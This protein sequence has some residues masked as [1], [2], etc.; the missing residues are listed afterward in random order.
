M[1]NQKEPEKDLEKEI[2]EGE[3][4]P[5][6]SNGSTNGAVDPFKEL[7]KKYL[8]L[9]AEFEN[10]KKRTVKER[11]EILKYGWEPIALDFLEVGDNLER[12][13]QHAKGNEA[14]SGGLKLVMDSFLQTLEKRGV[15][16]LN[17]V[18]KP[19]SVETQEAIDMLESDTVPNGH[20]VSEETAGYMLHDR[21]LRPARVVVSKGKKT[22]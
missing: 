15:R 9:Y 7:E 17:T 20:V 22:V 2:P 4:P 18:G 12:A 10:Y 11:S 3:P 14:L 19:F 5:S 16:R 13:L 21:L 1:S 6:E 8:Y